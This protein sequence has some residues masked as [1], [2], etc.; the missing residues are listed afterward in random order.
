MHRFLKAAAVVLVL[1]IV[2]MF[3]TGIVIYSYGKKAEPE[4]SDCMIILGCRL[5]SSVPSP[6]LQGRLDRGIELYKKGYCRYIIV[7]GGMGQGETITEAEAMKQYLEK[8]GVPSDKII[9]E[10]KS[11]STMTN[12]INSSKLMKE[13]GFDAA[14]IISNSYHLKR[15]SLMAEKCGI[16]AT[17][18]GVYMSKYPADEAA[19]FIREIAALWKFIVLGN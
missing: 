15:A 10:D 14:I 6:F 17:V 16:S 12:I 7:S 5:Y 18:S 3:L 11:V 8:N 4:K 1:G 9:C 2:V 19:G 13:K